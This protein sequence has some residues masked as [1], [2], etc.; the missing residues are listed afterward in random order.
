MFKNLSLQSR[1]VCSFL[2]MGLI[3]LVVGIAGWIGN[4]SLSNHINTLN[5]NTLPSVVGLWKINEGQ[6]QVQSSERAL[7]NTLLSQ[8]NRQV[9]LTRIKHAWEQIEEGFKQYESAPLTEEEKNLYKE[10]FL[11]LYQK[12]EDIGI[13]N[14][15]EVQVELVNQN[16]GNLP[17]LT[18]AKVAVNLLN[19]L[20]KLSA[21]EERTSFDKATESII[22][23]MNYSEQFGAAAK[24]AADTDVA[25]TTFWIIL[26]MILGPLT[27]IIF[28]IFFSI[29]IAKPL[30]SKISGIVSTIV[31]S[32]SEIAATA[33][34][35]ERTAA[36]QA[37]AVSQTTTTMDELGA[38]SRATAEQA[39][40][41]ATGARQAMA[42]TESG[43]QAVN[44]TL[45]EMAM[46]KERVGAIASQILRLSDQ[47][48]Q[49]GNISS[50]VSDVANQTNMLALNAAVEAVRAGDHGKG[51]AVV[52]AEIRK[53]ADQSKTSAQKIS[54]LVADIQNSINLTVMVTD[55][56]TKTV[57]EG[58]KT[59]QGTADAFAGVA[60]S[61][62]NI[63]VNS[64]QISLSAKQQAIAIQQVVQAMN[65]L[66][67]AATETASG[68][69]QTKV[70]IQR[71]NE[72]AL[73]LKV[74][75]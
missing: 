68:I 40:S 65:A 32:S 72:A 25:Q 55:E 64:Q 28:G 49:I 33:E 21:N 16:K 27:A 69:S 39:E 35:Q 74:V 6:T 24:K 67:V 66:N 52:A 1:L 8:Q 60:D 31:S 61:I 19:E 5:N 58:A 10:K 2:L 38:S 47:T 12:F 34:Q 46:L 56:G 53:L 18:A 50:L 26:G 44:R 73:N 7:L 11:R 70:G 41:A 62:H 22:S 15:R 57:Q 48:N 4:S 45:E 20:S 71:L 30:S 51:F 36:Q 29:T 59:A 37:A 9:E 14:P 63:A 54:T 43:S 23:V 17:Q 42:L 13:P 75:V 3:V